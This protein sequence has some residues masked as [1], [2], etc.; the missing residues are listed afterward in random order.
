MFLPYTGCK[1]TP[2]KGTFC[3]IGI[4]KSRGKAV[5]NME[6]PLLSLKENSTCAETV[7]QVCG[8]D[9]YH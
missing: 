5:L 9:L 7:W 6:M 1:L 2:L 4:G 8:R 3:G